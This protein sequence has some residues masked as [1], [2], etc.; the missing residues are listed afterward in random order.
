MH[1]QSMKSKMK[2]WGLESIKVGKPIHAI[3]V[4]RKKGQTDKGNGKHSS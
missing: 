4:T 1:G 2:E 3:D